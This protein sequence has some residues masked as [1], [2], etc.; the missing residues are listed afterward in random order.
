MIVG[1]GID[2]VTVSR[3]AHWLENEQ[4]CRRFFHEKEIAEVK[5]RGEAAA[6]SLAARFAA[7]EAFAKSLGTGFSG[8]ALRHIRV[9]N[10]VTGRPILIVEESAKAAMERTGAERIHLSLTHE[11]DL[12]AAQV[13]LED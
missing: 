8:L 11:G 10:E 9:E 13:I 12:A 2:L 5:S 7:K 3:I 1:T 6:M 4:L